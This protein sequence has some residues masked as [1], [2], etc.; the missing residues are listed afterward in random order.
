MQMLFWIPLG[1]IMCKYSIDA[2]VCGTVGSVPTNKI[3]NV[4]STVT[5]AARATLACGARGTWH[6]SGARAALY[7]CTAEGGSSRHGHTWN[8]IKHEELILARTRNDN[9]G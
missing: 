8:T 3:T 6:A 2:R 4:T 7:I 9:E 1:C 5:G